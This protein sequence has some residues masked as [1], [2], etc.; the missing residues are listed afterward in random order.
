MTEYQYYN[1][2]I[3]LISKEIGGILSPEEE[4][5]VY[6]WIKEHPDNE[7]LYVR[8]K[9]SENFRD[10]N[11]KH[12]EIDVKKGWEKINSKIEK[13]TRILKLKKIFSYA[14]A[15]L[16]P[17]IIAGGLAVY[18]YEQNPAEKTIVKISGI[19]PG[20]SRAVLV[21]DD[22]KLVSLDSLNNLEITEKDGTIIQKGAQSLNY[23]KN[24][25][26][27]LVKNIYNTI[28][29]PHGGEYNL[30]LSDGTR[31]Y[32][33][34]ES[35]IK[36]PVQFTESFREVELTGEAYFEVTKD[37]HKPFIVKT[38]GMN[39]EVLGTSFNLNAYVNTDK[40]LTTLVEGSVKI[41][42]DGSN[43]SRILKPDEQAAFDIRTGQT[44]IRKVDVNLYVAWKDGRLNFY[45]CRLEDIMIT[46]TRWY[47]ADVIYLN[48]SAKDLRFS[49]SLNRYG[50]IN[51][52]LDIIK[53][54]GKVKISTKENT[55]LFS[56]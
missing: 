43:E 1:K 9:N 11:L 48:P 24:T 25:E 23:S 26:T 33:N 8:I 56:E 6:F 12:Q 50:N 2:I 41:N 16:L 18:F 54:T 29:I 27:A 3:N 52:I 34:A 53:S 28:K 31:V 37:I 4:Q 45:D 51:Q 44:E 13:E 7:A 14:A 19:E 22:G 5:E 39:I 40:I 15:I 38:Q 35:T 20:K 10:R 17:F 32:L 47:T 21:L 46:L 30:V 42:V 55:I 36:Y 49:G